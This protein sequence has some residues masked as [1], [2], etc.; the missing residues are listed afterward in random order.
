VT[1]GLVHLWLSLPTGGVFVHVQGAATV[2]APNVS[3]SSS[4]IGPENGVLLVLAMVTTKLHSHAMAS[5]FV[6]GSPILVSF[7]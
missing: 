4:V 6:H 1:A 3:V 2:M 5:L 7:R